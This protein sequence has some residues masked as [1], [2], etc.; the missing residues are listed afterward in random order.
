MGLELARQGDHPDPPQQL[1]HC[2]GSLG[3]DA[4]ELDRR[5]EPEPRER[6]RQS[7]TDAFQRL[8]FGEQRIEDIG[9]HRLV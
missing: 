9:P 5:S 2:L 8:Y 1:R 7:R 3:R 6:L 4:G